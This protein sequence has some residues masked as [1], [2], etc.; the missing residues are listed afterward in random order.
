MRMLEDN[1]MPSV[2]K[3]PHCGSKNVSRVE[4]FYRCKNCRKDFGRDPIADDGTLLVDSVRGFR[5]RFGDVLS[6]SVRL[7]IN[8]V[9]DDC[10]F[11]VYD[12]NEGGLDKVADVLPLDEWHKLKETMLRT[13]Y[14]YDWDK[15][16]IPVNDGR[17]IRANNEWEFS[18]I[19]NEDEEYTHRGV[20]AYPVYWDRFLKLLDPFF[21]RLQKND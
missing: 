21:D 5:F 4:G 8:Q 19:V 20:D 6:G 3:C 14:V 2:P 7:R 10:L 15:E 17:E 13:L 16:Y 9:D 18:V 12:S 1:H 11:E